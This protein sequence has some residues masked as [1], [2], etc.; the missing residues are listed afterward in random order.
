MSFFKNKAQGLNGNYHPVAATAFGGSTPAA[1]TNFNATSGTN[2][3]YATFQAFGFKGNSINYRVS[4][5]LPTGITLNPRT[6]QLSGTEPLLTY[7]NIGSTDTSIFTTNNSIVLSATGG[8]ANPRK[9]YSFT[10][11]AEEYDPS[12]S[13]VQS[14][15]RSYTMTLTTP[16]KFRQII[17]RGFTISG[18]RDAIP[19][20]SCNRT[21]H[22]NDTTTSLGDLTDRSFNYKGA[23]VGLSVIY[24]F[25][26]TNAHNASSN[27]T[28]AFDMRLEVQ[29]GNRMNSNK[30][31][32]MCAVAFHEYYWAWMSGGGNDATEEYNLMTETRTSNN[33]GAGL[34]GAAGATAGLW[35]MN[36]EDFSI[37]YDGSNQRTFTHA[38]RTMS[39]RS[40][41]NPSNS[42]QQKSVQSKNGVA[43]A[44]GDGSYAGGFFFRQTNMVT[45]T[46]TSSNS[47]SKPIQNCGE[48][49]PD[50]GQEHQYVIGTFDGLQNNRA[51][52]FNYATGTGFEGGASMQSKGVPGRSSGTNG[53]CDF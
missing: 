46:L 44:G 39:T 23:A 6:G 3:T 21:T 20:R 22:S 14:I 52:R 49:N 41:G 27:H 53:W 33:I 2:S 18:Y 25:G 1:S 15:S 24:S 7:G 5:L 30:T 9:N 32:G 28:S 8:Y 35:C 51:W 37:Y 34:A 16:W 19:F 26:T 12:L 40:A 11:T 31:V 43:W 17:T 50:I 38:T 47:G 45:N 13:L 4:G 36:G 42:H 48:E 10:V 29:F